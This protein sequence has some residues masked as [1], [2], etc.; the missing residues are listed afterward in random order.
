MDQVGAILAGW[1]VMVEDGVPNDIQAMDAVGAIG[2]FVRGADEVAQDDGPR[3]LV[4]FIASTLV[5]R[6]RSTDVEQIG[7]L[8]DKAF[9]ATSADNDPQAARKLLERYG[10]RP[11]RASEIE[12]RQG[13]PVPRA[14]D[15]DGIWFS[16]K[17]QTL[18]SLFRGGE[19]EGDRWVYELMR[20]ASARNSRSRN[21]RIGG[22]SGRAIWLS[23]ADWDPPDS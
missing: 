15:G 16:E 9:A 7:V 22:I 1:W 5:Q 20:H 11:I 13:R 14:G 17:A 4:Q 23:R 19:F 2:E 18:R 8:I 12:D 21:V 6:D 10:I 3:Q